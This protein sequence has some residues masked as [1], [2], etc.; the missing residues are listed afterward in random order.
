MTPAAYLAVAR[1]VVIVIALAAVLYLVYRSGEDRV[2]SK[3]LQGLQDQMK[4]QGD[5]LAG[6]HEE[7]T[8]A[9]A[10]LAE[11]VDKINAAARAPHQPV[12][13]CDGKAPSK[14][15]VL[16]KTPGETRNSDPGGGGTVGGPRRDIQPQLTAFKQKYETILAGCRAE[17]A[18]WPQ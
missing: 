17:D 5:V 18:S 14:P 9:N 15:T 6:W 16:S 3:D 10:K 7:S 12:W 8:H 11:D 2:R 13:L 1:D 4:R